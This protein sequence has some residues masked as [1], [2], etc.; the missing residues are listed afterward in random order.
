MARKS[1]ASA[2]HSSARVADRSRTPPDAARRRLVAIASGN[3]GREDAGDDGR[4]DG[5]AVDVL[6]ADP[7]AEQEDPHGEHGRSR[8]AGLVAGGVWGSLAER[9]VPE[10]LREARIDPGKRGAI[11]LCTVAALAALVAA[12]AVWLARPTPAPVGAPTAVAATAAPLGV[13]PAS[14]SL[15]PLAAADGSD[16]ASRTTDGGASVSAPRS[17][18][19]SGADRVTGVDDVKGGQPEGAD[20]GPAGP[21]LVSVTGKVRRPGVVSVPADARVADAIEAAGG[22]A[23][24][25]L[26][27]GM[28]LAAH[29]TDGASVVVGGP[30][31][32]SVAAES[33]TGVG[34]GAGPAAATGAAPARVNINTADSAALQQL[35][36]VGPVTAEAIIAYRTQHGPFTELNQLQEVSGIGPATYAR[37]AP[38][39]G[40]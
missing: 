7:D 37:L 33:V 20:A 38:H 18:A 17:E 24:L 36:G 35:P 14:D 39:V 12:V 25:A 3:D 15:V 23:D 28:N 11:L 1:K 27:A 9:W 32:N 40:L 8:A 10:P 19:A 22:V 5:R 31:G 30:A 16:G 26:L 29:L 6:A 2:A 4:N 21:I 13:P 34:A